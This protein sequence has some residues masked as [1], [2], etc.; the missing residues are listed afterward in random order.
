GV[1]F[2]QSFDGVDPLTSVPRGPVGVAE[3]AFR[4]GY[5]A[6]GGV[7]LTEHSWLVGTF[8]YFQDSTNAHLEAPDGDVLHSNLIFPNT[9][10]AG[11]A[12]LT[13]DANYN[14][15]LDTGDIDYKRVL[16]DNECGQLCWLAGARYGHLHQ[17][18]STSYQEVLG[19]DT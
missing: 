16:V 8:T 18:L 10:N 5:R 14:I 4:A 3:L 12:P 6:G 13:A 1:P 17:A 9:I 11:F 15:R 2:A 7:A 19:S